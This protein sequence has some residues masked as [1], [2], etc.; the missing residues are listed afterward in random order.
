MNLP[1]ASYDFIFC[2]HVLEHVEDF[3]VAL[4]EVRRVVKGK[5]ICSFPMDSRVDLVDEDPMI[6]TEAERIR[7]FGQKDHRRL[8]GMNAGK[9]LEEAGFVPEMIRGREYPEEILPVVGPADYDMNVL[10]VCH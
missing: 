3:R 6:T 2:N 1:D 9:L 4:A 8:F 7:R 10:F 5:F